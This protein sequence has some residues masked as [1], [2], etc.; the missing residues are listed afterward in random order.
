MRDGPKGLRLEETH[1]LQ[2]GHSPVG[3]GW[4]ESCRVTISVGGVCSG[5]GW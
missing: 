1:G 5:V 2:K 3:L 4:E